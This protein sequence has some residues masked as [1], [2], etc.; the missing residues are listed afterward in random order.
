MCSGVRLRGPVTPQYCGSGT[1]DGGDELET[2][3]DETGE[4]AGHEPGWQGL[5]GTFG[6]PVEKNEGTMRDE[7]EEEGGRR[8]ALTD[9]ERVKCGGLSSSYGVELGILRSIRSK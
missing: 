2:K 7:R 4:G 5:E 3:G 1:G 9:L 6:N 8:R